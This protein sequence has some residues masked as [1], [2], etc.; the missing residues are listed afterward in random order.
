MLAGGVRGRGVCRGVVGTG[1]VCGHG[2]RGEGRRRQFWRVLEGVGRGGG[3]RFWEGEG[4]WGFLHV[5]HFRRRRYLA[6]YIPTYIP[7]AKQSFHA[8]LLSSS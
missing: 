1:R 2:G 7:P 3:L 4:G 8:F 6:R 5:Y